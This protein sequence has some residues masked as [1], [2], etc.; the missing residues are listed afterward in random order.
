MPDTKT[1]EI[2]ELYVVVGRD[3]QGNEGVAIGLADTGQAEPLLGGRRR[4]ARILELAKI[5]ADESG[6]ELNLVK[7][8]KRGTLQTIT[9]QEKNVELA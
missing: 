4:V 1:A 9:P 3:S 6:Q 5:L 7:F 8:T 2:D